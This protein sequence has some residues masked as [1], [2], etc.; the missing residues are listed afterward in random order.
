MTNDDDQVV[1]AVAQLLSGRFGWGWG[2]DPTIPKARY[3]NVARDLLAAARDAG[4]QPAPVIDRSDWDPDALT[5]CTVH[6]R[7]IP[8]RP[9]MR[10][11][12]EEPGF[13][14]RTFWS[15]DAEA[16]RVVRECAARLRKEQQ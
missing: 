8:C 1:E 7:F 4:W 10:R 3:R 2:S 13:D 15:Q 14:M 16:V 6:R 12:D 5:V 9:C 11:K